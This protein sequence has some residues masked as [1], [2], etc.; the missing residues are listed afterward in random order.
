MAMGLARRML[1]TVI[2][3]QAHPFKAFEPGFMTPTDPQASFS[4]IPPVTIH[5]DCDMP[6]NGSAGEDG[7]EQPSESRCR[8][9]RQRV[10]EVGENSAQA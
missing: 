8:I 4:S 5:Y 10:E 9:A 6:W 3:C 2:P 7:Q 1:A